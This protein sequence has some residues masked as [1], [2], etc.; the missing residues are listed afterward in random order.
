MKQAITEAEYHVMDIVWDCHPVSAYD[1][2][3]RLTPLKGWHRKTVNTLLSRLGDK[4]VIGHSKQGGVNQYHPLVERSLY[5]RKVATELVDRVFQGKIAP[6][7]AGFAQEQ[8]LSKDDIR[9]LKA[10]LQDLD[11]DSN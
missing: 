9:G 7:V 3:Q 6:L 10:L 11:D 2:A 1:I 5:Q 4:E 8:T